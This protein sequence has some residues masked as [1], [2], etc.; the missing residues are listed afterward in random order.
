[1]KAATLDIL[2]IGMAIF[3]TGFLTLLVSNGLYRYISRY[4][5]EMR[6]KTISLESSGKESAAKNKSFYFRLIVIRLFDIIVSSFAVFFVLSWIMPLIGIIILFDSGGPI[7][8]LQRRITVTNKIV[9]L[10]KFR[11]SALDKRTDEY[12]LTKVGTVLLRSGLNELPMFINVLIGDLSIVGLTTLPLSYI[13]KMKK[14]SSHASDRLY[15][16]KPGFISLFWATSGAEHKDV[17]RRITAVWYWDTYF[18][19][20]FSLKMVIRLFL[21][22]IIRNL[23][24]YTVTQHPPTTDEILYPDEKQLV[25]H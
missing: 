5:R 22:R 8:V 15:K 19:D 1:M 17:F 10:L 21:R 18:A 11:I 16:I 12:K 13:I 9:T 6:S 14:V 7:L 23:W 2:L 3:A 4:E 20:H 25:K 24:G